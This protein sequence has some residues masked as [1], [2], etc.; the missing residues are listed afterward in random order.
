M[1][2]S[3]WFEALRHF[4]WNDLADAD[5]IGHW[6]AAVRTLLLTLTCCAALGIGYGL[7]I[8]GGQSALARAEA[9]RATLQDE[10]RAGSALAA[11]LAGARTQTEQAQAAFLARHRLPPQAA[12]PALLDALATIARRSGIA[13]D[14]LRLR[15][16][17]MHE[18]Y[19]QQP[20]ALV[21]SGDYHA[22]GIFADAVAALPQLVAPRDFRIERAGGA[23]MLRM[24]L[25]ADTYRAA[26]DAASAEAPVEVPVPTPVYRAATLRSPFAEGQRTMPAEPMRIREALEAFDLSQLS[27]TGTLERQGRRWALIRDADG[28][29]TR[30][31]VGARLGRDQGRIVDITR[32]RVELVEQVWDGQGW[33]ERR[34][35]LALPGTTATE[36]SRQGAR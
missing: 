23:G 24:T 20:L 8:H 9:E 22:L 2:L 30:V 3:P 11:A 32:E 17:V 28:G 35:G 4:D 26:A 7:F 33:R 19:V 29:V 27:M 14:E 12:L 36:D 16:A 1:T 25:E 10:L 18:F 13:L 31:S 6:P 5:T 21:L 34:N 15:D